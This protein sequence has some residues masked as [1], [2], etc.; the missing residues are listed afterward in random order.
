M[1]ETYFVHCT[2]TVQHGLKFPDSFFIFQNP[3]HWSNEEETMKLIDYVMV[4]Y[5]VKKWEE[6]QILMTQKALVVL[7]AFKG[8]VT[9]HT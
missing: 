9:K 2:F 8:K 5:I 4:I 3:K 1:T 7:D 6:L